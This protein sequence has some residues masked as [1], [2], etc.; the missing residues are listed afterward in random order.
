[1]ATG[2]QD[3]EVLRCVGERGAVIEGAVTMQLRHSL[4]GKLVTEAL[5]DFS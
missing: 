1:M 5:A 4:D 3:G 2:P